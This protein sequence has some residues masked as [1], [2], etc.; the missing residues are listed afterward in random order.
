MFA[1]KRFFEKMSKKYQR[2]YNVKENVNYV[3]LPLTKIPP[4]NCKVSE[5]FCVPV[6]HTTNSIYINFNEKYIVIN[7]DIA[8]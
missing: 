8:Y 4:I 3:K 7:L 5:F 2:K 1:V 6:H